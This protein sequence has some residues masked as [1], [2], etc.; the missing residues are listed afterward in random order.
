M[1]CKY[2]LESGSPQIRKDVL[3][4]YMSNDQIERAFAAAHD[5]ELHT[6]AFVMFGLPFEGREQIMETIRLCARI[7][8]GRFR[9]AIF[10]PFPG[11]AGYRI[12]HDNDLIDREKMGRLGNYFDGSCLRFGEEHDLFIE[13]LGVVFHWYVNAESDWP[14]A[15]I[16]RELVDEVE[17]WDRAT[18][19]A[20][21]KSLQARDREL[22]EE[23]LEKGLPHYSI[24][25]SH[26]M[27]VHSDFVAWERR[28]LQTAAPKSPITYTLD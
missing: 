26:V 7:K 23:L 22:S 15:H 20:K 27:A 2:G 6:S 14:T 5:Y 4:R 10:F 9:W 16:Y 11:T 25:Y 28:E 21:K 8:M 13:K 3:W 17:S 1:I 18:F 12:A 24:R 19:D